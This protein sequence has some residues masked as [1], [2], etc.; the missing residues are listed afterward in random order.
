M[1]LEKL[2]LW[3]VQ[4]LPLYHSALCRIKRT[5]HHNAWQNN[6]GH[7]FHCHHSSRHQVGDMMT[8]RTSCWI[9]LSEYQERTRQSFNCIRVPWQRH[10]RWCD[11]IYNVKVNT[12]SHDCHN[13]FV[14]PFG[15]DSCLPKQN[16][17][18][19]KGMNKDLK[20]GIMNANTL[21][22]SRATAGFFLVSWQLA[23]I[24]Y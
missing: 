10:W 6:V 16:R 14:D 22:Q 23:V 3:H 11:C 20:P 24:R 2:T 9:I 8:H 7:Q 19:V 4:Y 18:D 17:L 21:R 5:L 1:K 12:V 13:R 15:S